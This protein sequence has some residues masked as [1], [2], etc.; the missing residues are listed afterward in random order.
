MPDPGTASHPTEAEMDG[1]W[2]NSLTPTERDQAKNRTPSTDSATATL[3]LTKGNLLWSPADRLV[4][5]GHRL[6]KQVT[7]C[8]MRHDDHSLVMVLRYV[9]T[10]LRDVAV[11]LFNGLR[12]LLNRGG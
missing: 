3:A 8:I 10:S 9:F 7:S 6:T 5:E 1:W 12:G 4:L 2:D 11:R